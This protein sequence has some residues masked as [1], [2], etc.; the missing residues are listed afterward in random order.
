MEK[1][2]IKHYPIESNKLNP[3]EYNLI[4]LIWTYSKKIKVVSTTGRHCTNRIRVESIVPP[5]MQND[6]FNTP[7]GYAFGVCGEDMCVH[8]HGGKT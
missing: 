1:S 2:R 5:Q 4:M 6:Q 3:N 7:L 8:I